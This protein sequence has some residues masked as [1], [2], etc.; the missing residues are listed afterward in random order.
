MSQE[1]Y[2]PGT[3]TKYRSGFLSPFWLQGAE[4]FGKPR[5]WSTCDSFR[6]SSVLSES[7]WY[8]SVLLSLLL[9]VRFT[10]VYLFC[11]LHL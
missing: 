5:C 7:A 8:F 2:K 4:F 1:G 10:H 11:C 6:G 3:Y 9:T